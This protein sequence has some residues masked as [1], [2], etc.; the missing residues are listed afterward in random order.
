MINKKLISLCGVVIIAAALMFAYASLYSSLALFLTK[1]L[2][3]S[4]EQ[5]D[6]FFATLVAMIASFGII[7]G[8]LGDRFSR[9]YTSIV[10]AACATLGLISFLY[11]GISINFAVALFAVGAA[12]FVPNFMVSIGQMYAPND[13]SRTMSYFLTYL[14]FNIGSVVGGG[15][16]G[17][18]S[19]HYGSAAAIAYGAIG[20]LCAGLT[21]AVIYKKM[22]FLQ[23]SHCYQQLQSPASVY[24]LLI[25]VVST[26]GLTFLTAQLLGKLFWCGVVISVLVIVSVYKLYRLSKQ[27]TAKAERSLVPFLILSFVIMI[28]WMIYDVQ[29][30]ALELF[31][32]SHV[33]KTLFGVTLATSDFYGFTPGFDV[34]I[35]VVILVIFSRTKKLLPSRISISTGVFLMGVAYCIL[36]IPIVHTRLESQIAIYWLIACYFIQSMGEMLVGPLSYSL[37]GEYGPTGSHGFMMGFT[38]LTSGFSAFFSGFIA[39]AI[40]KGSQNGELYVIEVFGCIIVATFVAALFAILAT[41][42]R[43]TV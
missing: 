11:C 10:G 13:H 35:G 15:L 26:L 41:R 32:E 23:G 34:L 37:V 40:S 12:F 29:P 17:T 3:Y 42:K 8:V 6:S 25:I 9:Y 27:Q 33:Q 16:S 24:S 5:A 43:S 38:R 18:L 20:M 14:F 1:S 30:S 28:F 36:L 19:N 7:G 2:H 31:V 4:A 21:F 22:P 39:I